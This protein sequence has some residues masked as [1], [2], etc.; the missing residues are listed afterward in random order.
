M[1]VRGSS[2]DF[3]D[4]RDSSIFVQNLA[5]GISKGQSGVCSSKSL[6][7]EAN[8][9]AEKFSNLATGVIID[10]IIFICIL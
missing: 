9:I 8:G 3:G 5:E 7:P 6:P 2:Q 4:N 1:K 10:N